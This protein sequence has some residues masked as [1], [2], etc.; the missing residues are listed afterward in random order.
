MVKRY[1]ML[2]FFWIGVLLSAGI[3]LGLNMFVGGIYGL[4]LILLFSFILA[5]E[6]KNLNGGLK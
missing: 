3:G 1:S 5:K 2:R 6:I 4:S